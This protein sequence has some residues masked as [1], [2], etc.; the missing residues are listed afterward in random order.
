MGGSLMG[1]ARGQAFSNLNIH[2]TNKLILSLACCYSFVFRQLLP[3]LAAIRA[4]DFRRKAVLSAKSIQK[5]SIFK[6]FII[7][8]IRKIKKQI[9]LRIN[10]SVWNQ[11]KECSGE[12]L[13]AIA[14]RPHISGWLQRGT[15]LHCDG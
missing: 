6:N 9:E 11:I 7:E 10:S 3:G 4:F 8:L 14:L 12:R 2:D 5:L 1:T 13:I 15:L